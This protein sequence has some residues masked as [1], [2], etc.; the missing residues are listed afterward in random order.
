MPNRH[1]VPLYDNIGLN[2][3]ASRRAD[4][5]L[6][7]RIAHYLDIRPAGC[8]LDIA[9]GTGNYSTALAQHGG[10]WH[11]LDLSRGMLSTARR[12]DS[13]IHLLQG[14]A[15]ALPYRDGTF[16]G[17]VCTMAL[18][19][20]DSLVSVFCEACRV[21]RQGR[22]VIFTSTCEQMANYWLNEYFP[23]AM[24]RSTNQ[25]PS[26]VSVIRALSEA[27]FAL[28]HIERYYVRPDLQD[29]FLYAGKH[30]P[31]V[32]LSATIRQGIS[33]FSTLIDQAELEEGCARLQWD[34]ESGSFR[35]VAE[36]YRNN[37]GDYAFFVAS[38]LP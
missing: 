18:H 27:D 22:L 31:E 2:Y 38:R 15:A 14:D 10:D 28:T 17:A 19:H 21:L 12:K 6:T 33:T 26:A 5:F 32:Y 36:K 30:H 34:I 24:E 37:G 23:I 7:Q 35:Q 8:Y 29:L 16:D 20:L 9:C 25:M 4:P 13:G 3:D 1:A 11:G